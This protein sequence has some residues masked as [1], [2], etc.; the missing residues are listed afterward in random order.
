MPAPPDRDDFLARGDELWARLWALL[1]ERSDDELR[2]PGASGPEWT[3]KDVL[4]HLAHWHEHALEG[5]S[6]I[7]EGREPLSRSNFDEWNARWFEED[8]AL[9]PAEARSRC[10]ESRDQ[11]RAYIQGLT[12]EQWDGA[13]YTWP[14]GVTEHIHAWADANMGGH[15]QEHLDELSQVSWPE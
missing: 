1:G 9:T 10:R 8:A 5:V 3:G 12:D 2:R 4:G 15:Y 13:T 11:L 7:V 14:D 6:A